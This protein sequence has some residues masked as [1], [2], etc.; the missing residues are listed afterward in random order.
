MSQPTVVGGRISIGSAKGR[1]YSLDA[2][3]GCLHWSIKTTA[4]VR[5]RRH[6]LAALQDQSATRQLPD[7][8]ET[9][10]LQ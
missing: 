1:L 4:S 2:K 9:L 3:T 8:K 7:Q 5:D 10:W 6:R